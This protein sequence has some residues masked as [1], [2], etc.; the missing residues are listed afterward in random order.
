M[1]LLVLMFIFLNI[2]VLWAQNLNFPPQINLLQYLDQNINSASVEQN[3][4]KERIWGWSNNG[5]AAFSI[6]GCINSETSYSIEF[7]IIDLITDNIL[8]N[9]VIYST[10]NNNFA[11]GE[12]LFNVNKEVFLEAFRKYNI[13]QQR[14]DILPLPLRRNNIVYNA[15][16]INIINGESE[17]WNIPSILEYTVLVTANNKS[18]I[19]RKIIPYYYPVQL[20]ICGYFLSPF[21]N[22]IIIVMAEDLGGYLHGGILYEFI[23]C[24][25]GVGFK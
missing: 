16:I 3:V 23:G 22:R 14:I 1:R 17:R 9:I 24:H 6:K 7:Y 13:I 2:H 25:L 4:R 10:S 11:V 21:E 12:D 15:Q 8:Y 20:Y 5:K 19:L 18:K